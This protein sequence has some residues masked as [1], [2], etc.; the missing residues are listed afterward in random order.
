MFG[1]Q[2]WLL[3]G[4]IA[5]ILIFGARKFGDIGTG[6]GEGIRNFKKSMKSDEPKDPGGE[7]RGPEPR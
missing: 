2:E 6:L 1:V 7:P 4:I 5:V 3:V